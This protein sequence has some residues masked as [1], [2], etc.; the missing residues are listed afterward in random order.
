M[1]RYRRGRL[2]MLRTLT[3]MTAILVAVLSIVLI[4]VVTA[5]AGT[6]R[7]SFP[8]TTT[9][10]IKEQAMLVVA[11]TSVIGAN[12]TVAYSC[13]PV[14]T[15]KGGYGGYGGFADVRLADVH[16]TTGSSFF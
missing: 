10:P 3:R 8:S 16:G 11:G 1:S 13:F 5:S 15:G 4:T 14:A 12:V 7:T 9:V 6:T 2:R